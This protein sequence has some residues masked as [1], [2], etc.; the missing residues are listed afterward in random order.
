MS[1]VK[2]RVA[3]SNLQDKEKEWV[4]FL[5][6]FLH[7]KKVDD[8][9][10]L[11]LNKSNYVVDYFV[12]GTVQT[13]DHSLFVLRDLKRIMKGFNVSPLNVEGLDGSGW[14]VFTWNFCALHLFVKD[15]R[16][17]YNI[18]DLWID[19]KKIYWKNAKLTSF[20]HPKKVVG[21]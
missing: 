10:I 18:E 19:A 14:T 13:S 7:L 6:K 4:L 2:K 21:N 17:Y 5:A 3:E 16:E 8:I 9:V 15:L 20:P 11:K 1:K 12:I